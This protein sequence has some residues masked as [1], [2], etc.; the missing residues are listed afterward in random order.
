MKNK[1]LII[2]NI[3]LI[4]V[5]ILL[6]R[7]L[8]SKSKENKSLKEQNKKLVETYEKKLDE[9]AK[10]SKAKGTIS[11]SRFEQ[12]LRARRLFVFKDYKGGK[13]KHIDTSYK[14]VINKNNS[15]VHKAHYPGSS[16]AYA[17]GLEN[18]EYSNDL[19]KYP[20]SEYGYCTYCFPK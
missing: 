13:F 2:S 9:Y 12:E 20:E 15:K 5:I 6:A 19:T 17:T 11:D 1:I 14:Y 4:I 10:A 3:I 8:T 18:R 16:S 7:G